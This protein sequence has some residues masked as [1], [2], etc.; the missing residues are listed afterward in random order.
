MG[1][2]LRKAPR[3]SL[4]LIKAA[5]APAP[6]TLASD[7]FTRCRHEHSRYVYLGLCWPRSWASRSHS[8]TIRT[9]KPGLKLKAEPRRASSLESSRRCRGLYPLLALSGRWAR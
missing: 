8:L 2:W 3:L 9:G 4:T 1:E 7:P 6:N 5:L